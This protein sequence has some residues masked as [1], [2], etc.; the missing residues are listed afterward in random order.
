MQARV[1][2]GK[3]SKEMRICSIVQPR[4]HWPFLDELRGPVILEAVLQSRSVN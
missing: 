4:N 2:K 1:S 3:D